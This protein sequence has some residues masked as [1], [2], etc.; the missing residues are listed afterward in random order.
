MKNWYLNVYED[1][2]NIRNG[3]IKPRTDINK[4]LDMMHFKSINKKI[5]KSKFEKIYSLKGGSIN[6]DLKKIN[7]ND[8]LLIQ[9]PTKLGP[10]YE[11]SL[12]KIA[13]KKG[14][15]VIAVVHDIDSLRF[16][17]PWYTF[18][19]RSFKAEKNF[20]N[21]CDIVITHNLEMTNILKKNKYSKKFVELGIFDYLV[22][23]K[24]RRKIKFSKNVSFTGNLNKSKFIFKLNTIPTVNFQ[25]YGPLNENQK[26]LGK[27]YKGSFPP[28]KLTEKLESG[29]GLIWDGDNIEGIENG[30]NTGN[31]LRYNNPYKLSSYISTGIP[32]IIWDKAAE[33]DFIEKHG[34]GFK[35]SSLPELEKKILNITEDEYYEMVEKVSRIRSKLENG[36]YTKHAVR[37]ALK[38]LENNN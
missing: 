5:F 37:R 8:N 19:Y 23:E 2:G 7:K 33:A 13:H 28:D 21:K 18:F 24:S 25:L 31:Y 38:L 10:F 1:D 34:I 36:F 29:F 35:I 20:L 22:K 32:V 12:L 11:H 16:K 17:L 9:Y 4:V 26:Y 27:L 15:K 3:A 6:K 14:I 30:I